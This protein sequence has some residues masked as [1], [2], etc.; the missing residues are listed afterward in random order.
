MGTNLESG[1]RV[2]V[3]LLHSIKI[4]HCM[5]QKGRIKDFEG[6]CLEEMMNV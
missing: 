4:M 3:M 1:A 5:F 2:S 6:F